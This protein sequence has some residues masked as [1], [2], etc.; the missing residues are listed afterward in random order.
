MAA[1]APGAHRCGAARCLVSLL[2][3]AKRQSVGAGRVDRVHRLCALAPWRGARLP[4]GIV[5]GG[6]PGDMRQR[7]GGHRGHPARDGT[8]VG[9]GGDAAGR[10]LVACVMAQCVAHGLAARTGPDPV[11]ERALVCRCRPARGLG[12]LSRDPRLP[13]LHALPGRFRSHSALVVLRQD[14]LVRPVSAVAAV[15][16]GS[17]RGLAAA[18]G[19]RLPPAAG[20]V[21]VHTAVLFVFGVQAGQV[22]LHGGARYRAVG[23]DGARHAV[24][25]HVARAPAALPQLLGDR[26]AGRVR[27]GGRIR[28][29]ALRRAR[30]RR[31]RAG[32][33]TRHRECRAGP[34]HLV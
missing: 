33:G 3:R 19:V 1:T 4:V 2:H 12:V 30:R 26:V 14:D 29:A 9:L 25:R 11:G 27:G 32:P 5:A 21:A 34:G 22:H 20:V 6:H 24:Q 17:L 16:G 7:S 13:E 28:I 15:S 8:R 31:R 23:S 18:Q 10:R